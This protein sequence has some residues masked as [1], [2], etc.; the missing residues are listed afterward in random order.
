[1]KANF[2]SLI[3]IV[4]GLIPMHVVFSWYFTVS[5]NPTLEQDALQRMNNDSFFLGINFL[6]NTTAFILYALCGL[7]SSAHFMYK[8]GSKKGQSQKNKLLLL[9]WI[10]LTM[11][12]TYFCFF[13]M[14]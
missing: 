6:H 14:M 4:L 12:S 7:L 9:C 5:V 2:L 13:T 8:L 1:M 11:T 3:F 10:V